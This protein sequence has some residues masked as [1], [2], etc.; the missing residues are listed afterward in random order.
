M[1]NANT[2]IIKTTDC[3][4]EPPRS[5]PLKPSWNT[6]YTNVFVEPPGAPPVVV[7][8]MPNVSKKA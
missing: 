2:I 4:D 6:L 7:S 3:A 8:I 1:V 5:A